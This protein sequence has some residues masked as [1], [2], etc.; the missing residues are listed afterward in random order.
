MVGT[1]RFPKQDFEMSLFGLPIFA[2]LLRVGKRRKT[3]ENAAKGFQARGFGYFGYFQ[4]RRFHAL[5]AA[6][7][8]PE[9]AGP[10]LRGAVLLWMLDGPG[11]WAASGQEEEEEPE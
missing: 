10:Q 1:H 6:A 4:A 9:Q 2:F 3:S 7:G 5:H 8:R 11:G